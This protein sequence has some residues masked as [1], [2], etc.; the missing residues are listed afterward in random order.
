[1][2]RFLLDS[3]VIIWHLRGREEVTGMLRV[4]QR[5]G[6]PRCSAISILEVEIGMKKHEEEKTRRFLKGIKVFDV[7]R[8]VASKAAQLVREHKAKGRTFG[9]GDAI[10]AGTC[11]LNNLVLV[12]YNQKHYPIE[13]MEFYPVPALKF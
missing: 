5:Y 11:L 10:I 9:L 7:T 2:S 6:L 8:E 1:M 4:L 3:D 12:T 13:D